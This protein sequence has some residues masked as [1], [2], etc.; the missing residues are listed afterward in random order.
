MRARFLLSEM[1]IGLRRN[2]SMTVAVI[3]TV[4]I[5]LAGLGVAWLMREQVNTMK[6]FWFGKIEVSVFLD[7]NVTQPESDAIREELN[8]L[9]QVERVY[10]ESQHQAYLRFKEQ[11]KSEPQLVENTREDA[12]PE[13]YR[14]STP[15][16]RAPSLTCPASTR[17]PMST[18]H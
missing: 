16:W 18:A 3:L 14:R 6:D 4:A 9:P 13:S 17:W 8:N 15:S 10:Y 2:L 1:A 12:L 5:S 11:F 7:H